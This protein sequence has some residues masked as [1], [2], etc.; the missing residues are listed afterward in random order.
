MSTATGG[1]EGRP[2]EQGSYRPFGKEYEI[3][4]PKAKAFM[5]E[6]AQWNRIRERVASLEAKA[7][8]DWLIAIATM[9]G[10]IAVSAGLALIA[11]PKAT[12]EPGELAPFVRPTLFAV[13]IGG[14]IMAAALAVLWRHFR[15]EETAIASDIC[16]EMNTIHEAWKEAT[17]SPVSEG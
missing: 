15:N 10:G 5:I 1:T 6:D 9:L 14:G 2:P 17:M 12:T 13:L 8:I 16:D 4:Q 3:P 7:G 11:L